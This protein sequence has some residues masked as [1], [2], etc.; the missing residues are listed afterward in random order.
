[1]SI[2]NFNSPLLTTSEAIRFLRIDECN[3]KNPENTLRYYVTSKRLTP[4]KISGKNFYSVESLN[5]FIK[6][7]TNFI[8]REKND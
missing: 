3:V 2:D 1:M 4:T 8:E 7:Q 5:S 6:K